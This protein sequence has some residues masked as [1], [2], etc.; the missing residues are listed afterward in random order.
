MM[1][2]LKAQ[3]NMLRRIQWHLGT[4]GPNSK[5][6]WDSLDKREEGILRV[7]TTWEEEVT[8][9]KWPEENG[10]KQIDPKIWT[11]GSSIQDWR[12]TDLHNPSSLRQRCI[13]DLRAIK[14]ATPGR[15]RTEFRIAASADQAQKEAERK[16]GKLQR[17]YDSIMG[18]GRQASSAVEDI[19]YKHPIT[20]DPWF[21]ESAEELEAVLRAHFTKAFAAPTPD[22]ESSDPTTPL[23]WD[24]I[25]NWETFRKH[26]AHHHLSLIHI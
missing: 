3:T 12:T 9:L 5:C 13:V 10:V 1:A 11:F 16:K 25:Q 24:N 26:C 4:G 19:A 18:K 20:G 22:P 14:R 7:T 8:G 2:G 6:H 23:N 15:K 21:P 17:S